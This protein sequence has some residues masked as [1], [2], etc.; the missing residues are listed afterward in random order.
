LL[1]RSN[2]G[3]SLPI[4][5]GPAVGWVPLGPGEVYMPGYRV[6]HDYFEHV[7]VSNTRMHNTVNIT[8]I[9]NTS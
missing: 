5:R 3:L 1:R 8:N 4:G 6:S 2:W 7:N 9:Y